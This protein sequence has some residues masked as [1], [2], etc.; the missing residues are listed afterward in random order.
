[1]RA[2]EPLSR[3]D[4]PPCS[5]GDCDR[6]QH[7]RGLCRTHLGRVRSL[8]HAAAD[9]P[10]RSPGPDGWIT[11]GYRGVV[12]PER[13]RHLTGGRA[14]ALEHRL[15]MAVLLDRPLVP[16]E[17][18]HHRNGSRTDN[19]P[20]NL[21]LWTRRQPSGQRVEDKLAHAY[22]LLRLYDPDAAAALGLDLD[23]ETGAPA[24]HERPPSEADSGL[25]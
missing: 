11:H 2:D 4:R 19:R 25:L 3:R 18:V 10:V 24:Q 15:V 5:I 16:G 14:H 17:S 8:G 1:V 9:E 21:E 7:G 22:E 20:E 13:L 6:P 23:P 12:V